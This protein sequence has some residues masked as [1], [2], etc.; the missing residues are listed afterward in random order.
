MTQGGENGYWALTGFGV[1]HFSPRLTSTLDLEAYNFR[2]PV[3]G[4]EDSL[5]GTLTVAY[6][7]NKLWRVALSG[8]ES[9]TPLLAQNSEIIARIVYSPS[10]QLS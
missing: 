3:N 8:V 9:S 10:N 1:Y 4:Q 2:A 5:I 7:L 6:E